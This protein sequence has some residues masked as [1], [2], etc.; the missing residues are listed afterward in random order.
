MLV[1][2]LPVEI[3]DAVRS[4]FRRLCCFPKWLNFGPSFAA[5][6]PKV[7]VQLEACPESCMGAE[8]F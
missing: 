5:G 8:G 1:V 3:V 2:A 7:V 4:E 6:I